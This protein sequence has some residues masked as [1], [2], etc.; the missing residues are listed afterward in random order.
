MAVIKSTSVHLSVVLS[1]PENLKALLRRRNGLISPNVISMLSDV[2]RLPS[3]E[4]F[5]LTWRHSDNFKPGAIDSTKPA[6]IDVKKNLDNN[7]QINA[8]FPSK[9]VCV[10]LFHSY[11][12]SKHFLYG[13]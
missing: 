8:E 7:T 6:S 4:F 12:R 2:N 9:E 1:R 13:R 10:V 3:R 11:R 5:L